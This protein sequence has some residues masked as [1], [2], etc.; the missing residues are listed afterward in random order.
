VCV[1]GGGLFWALQLV[2]VVGRLGCKRCLTVLTP[3]VGVE[4]VV[5]IQQAQDHNKA[6]GL[7]MWSSVCVWGGGGRCR[8]LWYGQ[9]DVHKCTV[10]GLCLA[11]EYAGASAKA[12]L[13]AGTLVHIS[14]GSL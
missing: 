4:P 3:Q 9:M 14:Q 8:W 1:W 12:T 13:S 10:L 2:V 11:H 6:R 7:L 5:G